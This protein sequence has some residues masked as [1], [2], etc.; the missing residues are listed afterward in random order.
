MYMLYYNRHHFV[1]LQVADQAERYD[2]VVKW[3]N[4]VV[5]MNADLSSEE[6]TLLSVA[7][8]NIVGIRRTAHKAIS[9]V[10]A[11]TDVSALKGHDS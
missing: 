6:R 1:L 9:S 3:M 10:M 11:K 5:T 4:T 7:Y 2:E 8:K